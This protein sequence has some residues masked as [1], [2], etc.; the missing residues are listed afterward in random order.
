M[1]L[2]DIWRRITAGRGRGLE[3]LARRLDLAPE[4]LEGAEPAYEEFSI[5]K[6]GGGR[7]MICAPVPELRELQRR[8]LRRLLSRLAAHAAAHAFER[9]R[10]IVTNARPHVG[11]GVVVC[12]DLCD[13]FPSTAPRRVHGYFR[14]IGW[15]RPAART[16]TRLTTHN[17]GLPQGAPTSPRLS[18]LVNRRL[19]MRLSGLAQKFGAHYSRYADDI[20]FS[21]DTDD[22]EAVR[23][24]VG[25][26]RRIAAEMGYETH[27]GKCR[28]MHAHERQKVTGLVVN[29][30]VNLPRHVRR[31]L[32][33]VDHHLAS[34][35]EA[36]L[37]PEQLDGWYGLWQ[38]VEQQR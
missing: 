26:T 38:M 35:R 3:E 2:R 7:R 27:P 17:G 23:A 11:R 30:R 31:R 28:I 15:N 25:A 1:G 36:T 21:L 19:D 18:N 29:D 33:A 5:P 16:L 9:D 8:I 13:F 4:L 20:T 34:D 24:I 32:R 6:R 14:A 12:Q 22:H 37:S 10:S